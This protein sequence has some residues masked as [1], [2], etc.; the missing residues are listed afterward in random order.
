LQFEPLAADTDDV[1]A[2]KLQLLKQTADYRKLA[3][4]R[5]TLLGFIGSAA[6]T[7]N[8]AGEIYPRF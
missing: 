8:S 4:K 5:T 2:V 1:A 7:R 3:Q 6:S